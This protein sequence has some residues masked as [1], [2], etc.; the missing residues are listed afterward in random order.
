LKNPNLHI[1]ELTNNK[2][3]VIPLPFKCGLI[4][5]N[6]ILS[7]GLLIT[8]IYICEKEYFGFSCCFAGKKMYINLSVL[9]FL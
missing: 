9:P 3:E 1:N 8:Y 7:A 4:P 5:W 6:K 2:T